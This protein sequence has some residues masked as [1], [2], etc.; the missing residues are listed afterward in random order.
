MTIFGENELMAG[1]K[2]KLDRVDYTLDNNAHKN[3]G[4]DGELKLIDFIR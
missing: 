2:W 1:M 4:F 3:D